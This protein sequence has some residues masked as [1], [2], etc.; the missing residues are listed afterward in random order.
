MNSRVAQTAA[1]RF[2]VFSLSENI[3]TG[4]IL[5]AGFFLR[6][7]QYLTGRSLWLDESMLALNIVNRDFGELFKPLD[8]D[9]GAP[10]GF[11]LVEKT[12]S[13][14]F[15][16]NEFSLRIFPLLIGLFSL[17]MFY[18]LL[19]QVT[20]GATL[21]VGLA[22]FAFNP[23]L[24][25][26][27]SE[28]KQYIVDVAAT[29]LLLLIAIPLFQQP[30]RRRFTTLAWV[31]SLALW[32]SHP[33]LF[34]LIGIGFA[35]SLFYL[36]KRDSQNISRTFGMGALWVINL[37]ILFTL[38]LNDLRHNSY[39]REYWQGAFVPMP[40][41]SDLTWYVSAFQMN[42]D[43]Q[44][45]IPYTAVVIFILMLAGFVMLFFQHRQVAVTFASILFFTLLASSFGL[46]P[47]L[48]RMGLFLV[49]I[50]I[51]LIA[52]SFGIPAQRLR[53]YQLPSAIVLIAISGFVLY[54]PVTR[55]LEQFTTPKYFEHIRPTMS[56]LQESWKE[57]DALFV[58]YGAV[59]AFEF[60]APIYE[61][62]GVSYISS[63]RE[64]YAHPESFL[65]RIAPLRNHHRVWVLLSHVYENKHF[66]EKDHLI[67]Y[68]DQIGEKRREFREQGTSV[69]LYLY[70]L[71]E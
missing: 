13:L 3:L 2:N 47:L 63:Q 64:D 17:W 16:R 59:P 26:Y 14:I 31:G 8:Y 25:Y 33:S 39:M 55:S 41:W 48:E 69:Y 51:L 30:A 22:L 7:R 40:P 37:G 70:D 54:G 53:E 15:G 10:I 12:F 68:L 49:P 18:L 62:T 6:L 24:I 67:S 34:V 27:S 29:I 5:L 45:G 58:S 21:W 56:Y 28:V 36:R 4:L 38:T 1:V 60:Y 32:F 65:E 61:I 20:S 23:R 46:Y 42:I 71:A 9:Q 66:N 35:L 57:G 19:K 52:K 11:I 50:G 44:F 43:S